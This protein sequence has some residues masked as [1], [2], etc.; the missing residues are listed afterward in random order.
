MAASAAREPFH[1][2]ADSLNAD[3]MVGGGGGATG[4]RGGGRGSEMGG[5]QHRWREGWSVLWHV[6]MPLCAGM[7][8]EV[9]GGRW[10]EN[11]WRVIDGWV[12]GRGQRRSWPCEGL[13]LEH[14]LSPPFPLCLLP[15]RCTT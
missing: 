2:Y 9:S 1:D 13:S 6:I 8:F 3:M 14:N 7:M 12:A 15:V 5:G 10:Y 11:V 4:E